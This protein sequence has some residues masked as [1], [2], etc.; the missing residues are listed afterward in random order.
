MSFK[1]GKNC[2]IYI[3]GY[4][5]SGKS[6]KFSVPMRVAH[7]DVTGFGEDGHRWYPLLKDDSFNFNAFY[8]TDTD[9]VQA[10]L[11]SLRGNTE[12][13][14]AILLGNTVEDEAIGGYG[15]LQEVYG[16]DAP[17][18]DMLALRSSFRVEGGFVLDYKLHLAKATQTSDGNSSTIDN[19]SSSSDGCEAILQVFSCG[20]DDALIVKVQ[21]DDN[22]VFTSPFDRI[23]FTTANGVTAERKTQTSTVQRYTRVTW[24]GTPPY[25]ASFA[26]IFKRN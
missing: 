23:T 26:V 4:D 11:K 12:A 6:N 15:A 14:I 3:A 2:R 21:D 7:K 22:P 9:G 25:S 20:A 18:G 8:D 16:L 13:V 10:C 17:I 19:G 1:A 5:I 24:T